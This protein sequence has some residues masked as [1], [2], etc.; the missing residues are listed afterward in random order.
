MSAKGQL[1]LN[2]QHVITSGS[3]LCHNAS[4]LHALAILVSRTRTDQ[5]YMPTGFDTILWHYDSTIQYG[6]V[7]QRVSIR[8]V[9]HH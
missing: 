2:S 4:G 1:E 8:D 7:C 5:I 3:T 9:C 6:L